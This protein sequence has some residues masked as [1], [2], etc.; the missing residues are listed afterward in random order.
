[1]SWTSDRTWI[2]IETMLVS[3]IMLLWIYIPA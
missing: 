1:M 3:A 2:V